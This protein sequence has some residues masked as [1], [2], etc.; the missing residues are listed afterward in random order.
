[1]PARA[2]K[3]SQ[4][5][6]VDAF[7]QLAADPKAFARRKAELDERIAKA[8]AAEVLAREG[9][10]KLSVRV[11]A[12]D[13]REEDLDGRGTALLERE[14]ELGDHDLDLAE[15]RSTVVAAEAAV[16]AREESVTA[17]EDAMGERRDA[18]VA[19]VTALMS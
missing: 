4:P 2:M 15:R 13:A 12:L 11:G 18:A 9:M 16:A 17:R 6:P 10:S 8:E 7:I 14:G 19:A 1:M 3:R 5:D